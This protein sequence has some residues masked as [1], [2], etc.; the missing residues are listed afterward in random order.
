MTVQA[1]E[2]G[3]GETHSKSSQLYVACRSSNAPRLAE[4][5]S[6]CGVGG[7]S[8]QLIAGDP[9]VTRRCWSGHATERDARTGWQREGNRLT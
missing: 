7:P 4:M 6:L 9:R 3:A 2:R 1:E 8:G 5:S